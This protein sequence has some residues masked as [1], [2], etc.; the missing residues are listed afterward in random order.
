MKK[1]A[2]AAGK[3]PKPILNRDQKVF[4]KNDS[5]DY[6][7]K[8]SKLSAKGV[9]EWMAVGAGMGGAL[10]SLFSPIGTA[11]GITVGTFVGGVVGI[12]KG[13]FGW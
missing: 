10:G 12:C 1:C 7:E 2:T 8:I 3:P 6:P 5:E 9:T 4:E 13:L 11:V